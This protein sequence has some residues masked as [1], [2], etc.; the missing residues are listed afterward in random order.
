MVAVLSGAAGAALVS[1]RPQGQDFTYA[2][3]IA[4]VAAGL[5]VVVAG[6]LVPAVT[7]PSATPAHIH[8]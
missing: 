2:F 4:A 6:V 1:S 8:P 7:R 5:A 3:T